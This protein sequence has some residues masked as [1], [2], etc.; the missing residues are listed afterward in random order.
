MQKQLNYPMAI[1]IVSR[2]I[3]V[4]AL[5][6]EKL[7]PQ[8]VSSIWID[9]KEL[10]EIRAEIPKRVDL[11]EITFDINSRISLLTDKRR[12]LYL[13][14]LLQSIVYQIKLASGEREFKLQEF[15]NEC[16]GLNIERVDVVDL[17]RFELRIQELEEKL[18]LSREQVITADYVKKQS[19]LKEFRESL[20]RVKAAL[21][22]ELEFTDNESLEIEATSGKSWSAFTTHYSLFSSKLQINTNIRHTAFDLLR[23]AAHE[24]YG[25]HHTELSLKD[26]LLEQGRGEHG[27]VLTFSPQTF[28]SEAIAETS[29]KMLGLM[30]KQRVPLLLWYYDRLTDALLN[31][32]SFWHFEDGLEKKE[33][34]QMLSKYHVSEDTL[35]NILKFALDPVWGKYALL[36]FPAYEF[37]N[38]IYLNTE[39]KS[40]LIKEIYTLPVLPNILINKLYLS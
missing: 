30:P 15:I 11:E 20:R 12:K 34:K 2:K 40:A 19:V 24:G 25:G 7:S 10:K 16:Y 38:Q 22:S 1:D 18:R 37:L 29:L 35:G 4:L 33:I 21:P 39:D 31:A 23:L 9:K 13:N 14:A 36:Y 28:M 3:L 26:K 17:K 5:F 27:F 32:A 8:S 6:L